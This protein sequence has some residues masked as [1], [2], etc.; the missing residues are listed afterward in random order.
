MAR[1]PWTI[2]LIRRGDTAMSLA[3]RY[4]V[5]AIGLRNSSLRI[6][7]GV[8]FA[9]SLLFIRKPLIIDADL[10]LAR[11]AFLHPGRR[12]FLWRFAP[13]RGSDRPGPHPCQLRGP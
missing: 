6:S 12:F 3:S 5:I 13:F 10:M 11:I 7:P 2:S 9:S 1:W 8:M 4:W